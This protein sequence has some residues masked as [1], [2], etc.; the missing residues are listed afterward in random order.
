[1]T[2]TVY[3][4]LDECPRMDKVGYLMELL[5]NYCK[6]RFEGDKLAVDVPDSRDA[7]DEIT[8]ILCD[9]GVSAYVYGPE[10]DTPPLDGKRQSIDRPNHD[11]N[12][13]GDRDRGTFN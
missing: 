9:R 11:Y 4:E 6:V 13:Y 5:P 2:D 3:V 1:M 8:N 10:D 7:V 12:S